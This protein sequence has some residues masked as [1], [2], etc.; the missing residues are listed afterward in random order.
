LPK[1]IVQQLIKAEEIPIN[2]MEVRKD[3]IEAKKKL[4]GELSQKI[5]EMKGEITK[6]KGFRS[7]RELKV[8]TDAENVKVT[9]D[10][11]L[12]NPGSWQFEVSQLAQKSSVLTNG[13]ED[14]DKTYLGV[15]Y[16]GYTLSNGEEKEIYIDAEHSTLS[17]IAKLVNG[18]SDQMGMHANIIN[19]G[20]DPDNPWRLVLALDKTGDINK[21]EFPFFYM[22]DGEVDLR[23][24]EKRDGKDAKVKLDGFEVEVG[25]NKLKDLIP[26]AVIDLKKAKPGEEF[27]IQITED[28]GKITEKMTSI[29][30]KIN[31]VLK[32]VKEQNTLNE[33]SDTS[34]TLGGDLSL[35]QIESRIR[36][37]VFTQVMTS[38]GP[39]RIGELGVNFN[40]TGLLTFDPAQFEKTVAANYKASA[41]IITG[42]FRPDGSKSDG[43]LDKIGRVSEELLQ[44]PSGTLFARSR[45]LQSNIDQIDRQI[46]T[47][48][49]MVE[50][51]ERVLK[52]KFA[53]LEE[54]MSRIK[55]QGAG[56]SGLGVSAGPTDLG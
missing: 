44:K 45:G 5:E 55:G 11:N 51:K 52:D 33:K 22:V 31:T 30:D 19:D 14:K 49:R 10:K 12:A 36:D 24:S 34:K 37:A 16:I 40:K 29:V 26:G 20:K 43:F 4:I 21:A 9:I 42:V 41:E 56:L 23:I 1:D 35:Q 15:G 25:N 54:T 17:G 6:N 46:E 28:T 32:F 8:D 38:S 47:R 18:Q 13:V 3:K 39:K 53:R 2:K 7:F 50:N 27:S 48:R